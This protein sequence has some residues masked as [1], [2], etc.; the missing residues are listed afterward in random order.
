MSKP[1]IRS[2]DNAS[3]PAPSGELEKALAQNEGVK[4]KVDAVADDLLIINAVLKQEIPAQAQTGDVAQALEKHVELEDQVQ[5]CAEELQ[6]VNEVLAEEI[7]ER[8]KL[9]RELAATQ[10]ALAA[11]QSSKR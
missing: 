9:E 5:Q 7:V 6:A 2:G 10:A 1:S 4:E 11:Q 8:E 3:S